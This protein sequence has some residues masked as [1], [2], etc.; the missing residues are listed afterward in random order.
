MTKTLKFRQS[1]SIIVLLIAMFMLFSFS[2]NVTA[3]D[4]FTANLLSTPPANAAPGGQISF[5]GVM[6]NNPAFST[7]Y[8][9][10][11][12]TNMRCWVMKPDFTK[13]TEPIDVLYPESGKQVHLNFK[14]KFTIPS[15]AAHGTIFDF[16]LVWAIYY[17]LGP[18]ASVS[19]VVNTLQLSNDQNAVVM[20]I[21]PKMVVETFAYFPAPLKEGT[22]VSMSITF[23][24]KGLGK[25]KS[26]AKYKIKCD[27]LSGG[28][29]SKKCAVPTTERSFG[30][31]IPPGATHSVS[32]LGAT[33][34]ETGQYRVM[35]SF[36]GTVARGRPYTVILNVAPKASSK[37][38]KVPSQKSKVVSPGA[39]KAFNPQPEPPRRVKQ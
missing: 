36:P 3:D 26:D 9:H 31:E 32:L 33:P 2:N 34:A 20:K 1:Q 23:K 24:N 10:P 28:G 16:Y 37:F 21:K 14:D 35:I 12:G 29:P 22:P 27:I 18:K 15:D 19:V 17:P 8:S 4:V 38:N 39:K 13:V 11:P 6:Y 30:K 7:K 5:K 25:C